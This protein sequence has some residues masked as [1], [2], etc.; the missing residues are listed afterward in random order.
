MPFSENNSERRWRSVRRPRRGRNV[1]T[2]RSN[3]RNPAWPLR[4]LPALEGGKSP[5]HCSFTSFQPFSVSAQ[6]LSSA[7][8]SST[9]NITPCSEKRW[10]M[11]ALPHRGPWSLP[12]GSSQSSCQD[13]KLNINRSWHTVVSLSERPCRH[14]SIK[15]LFEC[16]PPVGPRHPQDKSSI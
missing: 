15:S 3:G 12:W 7:T 8:L 13:C 2:R 16:R 14:C 9:L 10:S 1:S 5:W 11:M 6:F 4:W